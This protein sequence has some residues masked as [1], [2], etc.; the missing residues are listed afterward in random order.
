MGSSGSFLPVVQ[1]K[2][3]V[4]SREMNQHEASSAKVA[5]PWKGDCKGKARSDRG[6]D[7]I[8]A[9]CENFQCRPG[10]V[11]FLSGYHASLTRDW[12]VWRGCLRGGGIRILSEQRNEKERNGSEKKGEHPD[13]DED[14]QGAHVLLSIAL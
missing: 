8:A 4:L 10:G 13:S 6:V 14:E 1:G 11:G 7:G 5:G 12:P 2:L 3:P 9:L